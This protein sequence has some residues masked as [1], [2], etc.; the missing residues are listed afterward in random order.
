MFLIQ[1]WERNDK[2]AAIKFIF[3]DHHL[4]LANFWKS[5]NLVIKNRTFS[6]VPKSLFEET[7]ISSYLKAHTVFDSSKDEIMLSYHK[8]LDMVNIFSVPKSLVELT[9]IVYPGKKVRFIHQSSSL[10][11]GVLAKNEL[12]QKDI[13]IYIDRFGLHI[14]LVNDKNL[15]FYNQ[16]IIKKFDNYIKYIR[17]VANELQFDLL[18][19]RISLYGYLGEKHTS[20]Q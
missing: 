4:L 19:D 10:I 2:H 3:D 15:V 16:Y 8:Q 13:A 6:F 5:I 12:G 7:N 20:L 18:N 1:K 14:I 9:S 17:M 11:N